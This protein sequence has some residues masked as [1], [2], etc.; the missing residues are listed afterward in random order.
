M[1]ISPNDHLDEWSQCPHSKPEDYYIVILPTDAD[2][3]GEA[4]RFQSLE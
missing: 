3:G 2:R 4:T 1:Q